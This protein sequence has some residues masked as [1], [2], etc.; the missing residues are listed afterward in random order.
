MLSS[1]SSDPLDHPVFQ[2]VPDGISEDWTWGVLVGGMAAERE[3]ARI[4]GAY[5]RAGDI[6]VQESLESRLP[7]E[8]MY[9]ILFN[10]R[11]TL[12]LY[13]KAALHSEY[14]GHDLIPLISELSKRGI[15]SSSVI[16][17]LR[18]FARVDPKSTG[19]RY[20]LK[21]SN[22]LNDKEEWVDLR[23][24]SETVALLVQAL[25]ASLP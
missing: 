23:H 20:V 7:W 19:F 1:Q 21:R 14:H 25:E 6:L 24:L 11:H 5:R 9:P 22:P 4:A 10:Y 13:L 16:E 12:E 18:E 15:V 2:E 17:R 8:F 3:I